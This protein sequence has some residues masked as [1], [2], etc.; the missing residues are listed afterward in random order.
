VETGALFMVGVVAAGT[1]V[2]GIWIVAAATAPSSEIGCG[3]VDVSSFSIIFALQ[4][5]P[6]LQKSA[7]TTLFF[8]TKPYTQL[9]ERAVLFVANDDHSA[10][11]CAIITVEPSM[12][13]A[14]RLRI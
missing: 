7:E 9:Y 11:V 3:C 8:L 2:A 13:R 1:W 4:S 6:N 14:I 5:N 10:C 12:N